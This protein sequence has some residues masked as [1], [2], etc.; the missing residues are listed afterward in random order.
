MIQEDFW[1]FHLEKP[2]V[3][4]YDQDMQ[5]G[6]E[7]FEQGPDHLCELIS[8]LD[9]G[10]RSSCPSSQLLKVGRKGG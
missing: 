2:I 3:S 7:P 9:K 6:L 8:H 5:N 10:F 4:L 1:S